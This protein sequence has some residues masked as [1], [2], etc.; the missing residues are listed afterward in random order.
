MSGSHSDITERKRTEAQLLVSDRM[1]SIGT[2]AAGVAHEVNNPL[3]FVTLNVG[4]VAAS[5]AAFFGIGCWVFL[6]AIPA[7]NTAD[8]FVAD[9][10]HVRATTPPAPRPPRRR[11]GAGRTRRRWCR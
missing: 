1:V 7:W 8:T 6:R 10:P 5:L 3:T 11:R 2:L 4:A 9:V